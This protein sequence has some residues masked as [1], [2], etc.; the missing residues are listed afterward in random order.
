MND[1][2]N[3]KP[4]RGVLRRAAGAFARLVRDEQ[5]VTAIEYGLIACVV[6]VAIV[7]SV[8]LIGEDVESMFSDT[9][10]AVE[11]VPTS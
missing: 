5:G 9:K 2:D 4:P 6:A 7:A 10:S 8:I 3:A 1:I 11:Q